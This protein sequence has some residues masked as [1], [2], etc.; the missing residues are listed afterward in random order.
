[1]NLAYEAIFTLTGENTYTI[2]IPSIQGCVSQGIGLD[3]SIEMAKEAASLSILAML[4]L[5]QPIPK[6]RK[7]TEDDLQ[8]FENPIVKTIE[9]DINSFAKKH[10][11]KNTIVTSFEI[12]IWLNTLA[13]QR[14]INFPE[15]LQSAI[16]QSPR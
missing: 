6:P 5:D 4:E 16:I 7:T 14:Q 2:E 10:A 3:D 15:A 1:M 9:V 13:K 12:P 8:Y 11:S